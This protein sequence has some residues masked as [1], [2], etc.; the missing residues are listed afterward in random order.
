MN[1]AELIEQQASRW[2]SRRDAQAPS[3]EDDAD[4]DRWLAADIRHRVAY[5]R[6]EGA[7]KRSDRLRDL[8]P[9]DRGVDPDLLRAHTL[10]SRWPVAPSCL[11]PFTSPMAPPRLLP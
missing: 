2:L 7:W 9:L 8:R 3:A 6:L 10:R 4:F 5:L 1:A 11:R